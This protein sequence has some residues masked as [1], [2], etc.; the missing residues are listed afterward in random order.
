[1]NDT[2]QHQYSFVDVGDLRREYT[3]AELTEQ[4]VLP[5]PLQQF[6][7]WLAEAVQQNLPEPTALTL[8]TVDATGLPS[9]RIVLLKGITPQGFVFYTNYS[10]RKGCELDGQ[11]VAALCF[12]WAELERQV[13]VEGTVHRQDEAANLAYYRTRPRGSRLGAWAS[14]QSEVL[15]HRSDL[16]TRLTEIETRFADVEDIPLPPFWGGYVVVPHAI[17]FWQGRPSR[18][19]DRIRYRRSAKDANLWTI[20]RLAP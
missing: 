16:E 2:P 9:A 13:R 3:L 11:G 14:P 17:E 15:V 1:M 7:V 5:D 18:L 6:Q 4:S 19:H 20:D 8:C 10:S 12:H